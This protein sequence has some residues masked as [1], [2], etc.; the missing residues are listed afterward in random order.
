MIFNSSYLNFK[1][2]IYTSKAIRCDDST[3]NLIKAIKKTQHVSTQACINIAGLCV[4]RTVY[5]PLALI[6]LLFARTY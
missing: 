1:A 3:E 5:T 2:K 6:V 4:C